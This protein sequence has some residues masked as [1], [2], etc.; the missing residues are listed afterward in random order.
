MSWTPSL[1]KEAVKDLGFFVTRLKT[2][3]K[4][5]I[6]F[7]DQA[8]IQIVTRVLLEKD[9]II[10]DDDGNQLRI[11]HPEYMTETWDVKIYFVETVK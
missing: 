3:K 1:A 11:L 8:P 2:G 4:I 5:K 7:E 10:K 9:E 6:S